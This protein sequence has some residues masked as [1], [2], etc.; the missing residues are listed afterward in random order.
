MMDTSWRPGRKPSRAGRTVSTDKMKT[1]FGLWPSL[2][3]ET[4]GEAFWVHSDVSLLLFWT[5]LC[6][7][8]CVDQVSLLDMTY[9][10]V[11][12]YSNFI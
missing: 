4:R 9:H 10:T 2:V 11:L 3:G 12:L 7:Y 6:T 8:E 5:T 1:G